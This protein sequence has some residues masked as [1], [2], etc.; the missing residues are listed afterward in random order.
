MDTLRVFANVG[1]QCVPSSAGSFKVRSNKHAKWIAA[2]ELVHVRFTSEMANAW[3]GERIEKSVSNH[4]PYAPT[5]N[6]LK[7]PL[8]SSNPAS[9]M[10]ALMRL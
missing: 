6:Y 3:C 1:A 7:P 2:G 8:A 4:K 5:A 9:G 10:L